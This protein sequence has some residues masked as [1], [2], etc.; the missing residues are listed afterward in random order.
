[1][2]KNLILLFL[3]AL[4]SFPAFAGHWALRHVSSGEYLYSKEGQLALAAEFCLTD[5]SFSWLLEPQADGSLRIQ[6][7]DC[8]KYLASTGNGSMSSVAEDWTVTSTADQL[9]R[10]LKG[11][12]GTLKAYGTDLWRIEP[13]AAP[14]DLKGR[15]AKITWTEYQAEHGDFQGVLIGPSTE[16][17]DPASEAVGRMGVKL[18]QT[19]DRVSWIAEADADGLELRYSIPDAPKGG[20]MDATLSLYINDEKS[21]CLALTSR[22]AWIYGE[23][24]SA[25]RFWTD[26][27]NNGTPRK[28]FDTQRF[29]LKQ[30]ILAGDIVELRRENTDDAA[31]YMIDMIELEKI[32]AIGERPEG[33]LSITD[34][35][36]VA[37]DGKDDSEALSQS[38]SQAADMGAAGVWVPA[39]IFDFFPKEP[40]PEDVPGNPDQTLYQRFP[41]SDIHLKGAGAWHSE[42][43]GNGIAF[44]CGTRWQVSDLAID[45]QGESRRS[46]MLFFG[47]T[48]QDSGFS[49]LYI[50]RCGLVLSIYDPDSRNFTVRNS[51]IR[52]TFAGGINLRGGH[53]NALIENVHTRGTGDDALIFWST[54][55]EKSERPT[56]DSVIRNCTC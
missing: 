27:P 18:E 42:L 14:V 26:D 5:P 56:R 39:G 25:S 49:N 13:V 32:P 46:A 54:K 12:E 10:T 19:G 2:R 9:Y 40:I 55:S 33:F 7:G 6:S 16:L 52:S 50:T 37:N 29:R 23:G 31:F 17:Q 20:G 34:F 48:G 11:K 41:L 38:L 8:A 43:R 53:R 22:H 35:G 44:Q 47:R 45:W 4:F 36:A 30:P 28:H 15:G 3:F 51:R 1:M 24:H 21:E